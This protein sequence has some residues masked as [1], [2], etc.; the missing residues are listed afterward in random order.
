MFNSLNIISHFNDNSGQNN[1]KKLQNTKTNSIVNIYLIG[2]NINHNK[3]VLKENK[4]LNL[5]SKLKK[6]KK[7]KN[8]KKPINENIMHYSNNTYNARENHNYLYLPNYSNNLDMKINNN[9]RASISSRKKKFSYSQIIKTLTM[10]RENNAQNKPIQISSKKSFYS[11]EKDMRN[12]LYINST[13]IK[14]NPRNNKQ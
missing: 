12:F 14:T 1:F 3:S 9:S 10:N 7:S 2:H 8:L 6:I 5:Q 11:K 13:N 4:K